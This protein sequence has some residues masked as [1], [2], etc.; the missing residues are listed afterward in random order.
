MP[1]A[2]GAG[3]DRERVAEPGP[4]QLV[5]GAGGR[6]LPCA[7]QRRRLR[8][9]VHDSQHRG[10]P[11][12]E[13]R[14]HGPGQRL[15]GVLSGAGGGDEPGLR[16]PGLGLRSRDAAHRRALCRLGDTAARGRRLRGRR[17]RRRRDLGCRRDGPPDLL[18]LEP[19]NGGADQPAGHDQHEHT[20]RGDPG[21]HRRLPGHPC[22]RDGGGA[23]ALLHAQA[24]ARRG[25]WR[26]SPSTC[27]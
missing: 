10:R 1:R 17:C 18:H 4:A 19:G 5:S 6:Q 21:R 12:H 25:L 27:R 23:G 8:P 15:P 13:L 20:R 24:A 16:E 26:G 22:R 7:A 14:G 2:G 11:R 9:R 3:P